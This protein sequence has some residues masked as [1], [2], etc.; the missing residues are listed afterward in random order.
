MYKSFT[1]DLWHV[2]PAIKNDVIV[3]FTDFG[4]AWPLHGSDEG[5]TGSDGAGHARD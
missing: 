2:A 3:L 5:D 4:F 1:D